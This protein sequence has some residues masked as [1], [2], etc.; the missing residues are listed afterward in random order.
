MD[1]ETDGGDH[2]LTPIFSFDS[3]NFVPSKNS[4]G[5]YTGWTLKYVSNQRC[6]NGKLASDD[7]GNTP[8]VFTTRGICDQKATT[9]VY[10]DYKS[11]G[12]TAEVT[13]TSHAGC[14]ALDGDAFFEAIEPYMGVIGI[15]IGGLMTFAGAKFLFQLVAAFIGCFVTVVVYGV[16]SN[17][18][19]GLKTGTGPKVGLLCVAIALGAGASYAGYKFA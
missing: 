2:T 11:E 7:S 6:D 4:E 12:C 9:P 13:V 19:F 17:F 14:V 10:S 1:F 15:L 18:F 8:F 16:I 5:D 3:A